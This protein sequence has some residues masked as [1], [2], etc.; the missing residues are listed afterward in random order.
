MNTTP[1][2][3][4]L[5][6]ELHSKIGGSLKEAV[7]GFNDGVVS[8]FAVIAGLTGGLTS[9]KTILLGALATLTAGAFSM[10]L[11]T[12]LGS[13]SEK[14]LYE[15][16][17]RR[18]MDEMKNIPERERQ[19]IR[20]IYE[21]RGFKGEL[22]EKVVDVITSD[23]KVWLDV[24]MKEELGFVENPPTPWKDGIVMSTAFV[25]GSFIPTLPYL[26]P[27]TRIMCIA[28]PCIQPTARLIWGL[29]A[30]FIV[31]LGISLVGLLL[32]GALKTRFTRRN[33]FLSA[34]ESLAVGSLAAGGSYMVGIFL[35]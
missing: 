25:I 29:P 21:E 16:E 11:G 8:T 5:H 20:D 19:E 9:E 32:A 27:K 15:S 17:R 22:L 3:H 28:E 12:F 2:A 13:K 4:N 31:S 34:L 24:M 14:D 26:L 33:I 23:E 7:F 10:G 1:D 18:E 30:I 6:I 35:S